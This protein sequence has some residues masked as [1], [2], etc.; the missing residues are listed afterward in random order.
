MYE[1]GTGVSADTNEALSWF[2]LSAA[3]GFVDAREKVDRY[4]KVFPP[5]HE[6]SL[7]DPSPLSV[8]QALEEMARKYSAEPTDR[9]VR[10]DIA[11]PSTEQEYN[12]LGKHAI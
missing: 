2:R 12:D 5:Q 1:A 10:D 4:A 3:Q 6:F 8:D 7:D 9:A 11:F